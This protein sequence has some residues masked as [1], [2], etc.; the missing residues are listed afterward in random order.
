MF[1]SKL[2][3]DVAL[4]HAFTCKTS[5]NLAFHV[6]D[7]TARVIANHQKL[8][9]HLHY[10]Y[11]NLVHMKQI[12]SNNVVRVTTEHDFTTPI[13]CDAII[14]D[15][16]NIPLMVMTADCTPI[17]LYDKKTHAIAAIHAGRAGAFSNIIKNTM[18][19]MAQHFNSKSEN[20]IAVLG[21][22]ICHECYE[23]NETIYEEAKTLGY[24]NAVVQKDDRFFLHVNL[25]LLQ[26]LRECGVLQH[27]I[28]VIQHCTSCE[29]HTFFSYRA[30]DG[31]T[32]RQ[33]GV[34]MLRS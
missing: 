25:I 26:Q 1:T 6:G 22:S 9:S 13:E 31:V 14:T 11:E 17:L 32:G 34:M 21:P 19:M 28:D 7:D 10:R 18:T 8:A 33:A 3:A 15:E 30:E 5:D 24:A 20:I 4:T 2:L 27:H 12:H 16:P 23:V 29:H